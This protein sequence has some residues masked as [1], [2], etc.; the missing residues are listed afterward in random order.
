MYF[1]LDDIKRRHSVYW[2]LYNGYG[3][4]DVPTDTVGWN[5]K[6]GVIAG[7]TATMV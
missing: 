6:R 7:V 4:A 2:D 5:Y 1:E 3:W